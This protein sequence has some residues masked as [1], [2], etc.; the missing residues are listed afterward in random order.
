MI[1]LSNGKIATGDLSGNIEV[2]DPVN[3]S[4]LLLI[5]SR[6]ATFFEYNKFYDYKHIKTLVELPNGLLASSYKDYSDVHIWQL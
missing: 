6:L 2:W 3:G 1:L 4:K 5:D